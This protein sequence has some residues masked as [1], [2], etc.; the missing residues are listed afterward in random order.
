MLILTRKAGERIQI[1]K[2]IWVTIRKIKAGRVSL[3]VEAPPGL[4]I[5]RKDKA[6][7]EGEDAA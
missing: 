2:D 5:D 7:K 3:G 6:E 1:G 4:K